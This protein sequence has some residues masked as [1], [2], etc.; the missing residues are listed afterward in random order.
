MTTI[1][2]RKGKVE[3]KDDLTIEAGT[4]EFYALVGTPN[5][6]AAVYMLGDHSKAIGKKTIG[7]ILIIHGQPH[8]LIFKYV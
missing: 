8:S 2:Q 4:E 5:G 1:Y 3:T 6:A 7:S